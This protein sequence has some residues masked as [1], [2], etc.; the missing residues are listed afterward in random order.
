MDKIPFFFLLTLLCLNACT[1]SEQSPNTSN[2]QAQ[3]ATQAAVMDTPFVSL[4]NGPDCLGSETYS[5]GEAIANQFEEV[6]YE[7]VMTWFCNGAEFEDIL[8]SLSDFYTVG[9]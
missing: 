6:T 5:I 4:E 2:D 8:V 1:T 3:P 7:E 9:H